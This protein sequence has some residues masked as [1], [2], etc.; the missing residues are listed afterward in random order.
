M[1][2]ASRERF[3]SPDE[4]AMRRRDSAWFREAKP[5]EAVRARLSLL[6]FS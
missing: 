4:Y 5:R 6:T 1:G 3:E 2:E